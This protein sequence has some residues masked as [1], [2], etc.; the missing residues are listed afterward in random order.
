MARYTLATY[1]AFGVMGATLFAFGVGMAFGAIVVILLC[2]L[3]LAIGNFAGPN[4]A[5]ATVNLIYLPMAF[6]SGLWI[7]FDVL[8]KGIQAVAPF[9][10]S[11]HLSQIALQILGARTHGAAGIAATAVALPLYFLGY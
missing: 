1:G 3:G 2:A 11:F 10:P 8:P 4:S 6:C 9:L 5:P 7:P